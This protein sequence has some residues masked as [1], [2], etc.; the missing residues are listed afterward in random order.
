LTVDGEKQ[1]LHRVRLS[2][3]VLVAV[4]AVGCAS[5]KPLMSA[6]LAEAERAVEEAQQA[7]AAIGA[8]LEYKAAQDKLK[9]A[10]AAMA[11]GNRERA[12]RSA[13]QA[14]IDAEYARARTANQRVTTM[15]DQMAQY[16]K[17]LRQDLERLPQ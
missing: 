17:S 3:L 5:H 13:E 12:I 4:A 14:A 7:G 10:Q 8:P 9:T 1:R 16:I 2:W 15:A 11:K 6:K